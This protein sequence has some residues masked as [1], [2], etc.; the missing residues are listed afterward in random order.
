MAQLR[1]FDQVNFRKSFSN[2]KDR[3][4]VPNLIAIQKESYEKFLQANISPEER[5]NHGIESVF[6]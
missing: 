3:E 2:N 6:R 1:N 4:V 5:E